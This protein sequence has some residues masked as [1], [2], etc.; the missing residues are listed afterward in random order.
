MT[1]TAGT[2]RI[3][4]AERSAAASRLGWY[5]SQG[6]LDQTEF[7]DRLDRAMHARTAAELSALFAD[8]PADPA[9]PPAAG[10]RPAAASDP[11]PPA[12]SRHGGRRVLGAVLLVVAVAIALGALSHSLIVWAAV[13]VIIVAMARRRR[14]R[15]RQLPPSAL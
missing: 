1:A 3:G 15:P 12:P 6:N 10:A 14:A 4:D 9:A 5:F 11:P 13:L 7:E 2:T 8:L